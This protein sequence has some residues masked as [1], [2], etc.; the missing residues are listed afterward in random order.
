ME[1]ASKI[2]NV[3]ISKELCLPPVKRMYLHRTA[4]LHQSSGEF[5]FYKSDPLS[6][7]CSMLAEDAIKAA[8]ADYHGKNPKAKITDLAGTAK[9]IRETMQQAA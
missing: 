3:D 6:V 1:D 5:F 7:H 4:Q 9:T 8:I 2:R